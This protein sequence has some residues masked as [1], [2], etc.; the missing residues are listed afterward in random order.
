MLRFKK[1]ELRGT[2]L[3]GFKIALRTM[4]SHGPQRKLP[5]VDRLRRT[6]CYAS[7]TQHTI[8]TEVDLIVFDGNILHRANSLA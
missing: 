4:P 8:I 5:N 6:L 3:Q 1:I 2:I 7:Q